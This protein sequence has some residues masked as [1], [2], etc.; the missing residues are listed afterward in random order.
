VTGPEGVSDGQCDRL[1]AMLDDERVTHLRRLVVVQRRRRRLARF[2]QWA[3]GVAQH[4]LNLPGGVQLYVQPRDL[5][6]GAFVADDAVY[7]AAFGL[8]ARWSR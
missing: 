8:V 5:W 1:W 3:D 6:A 2:G 4:R 7:F